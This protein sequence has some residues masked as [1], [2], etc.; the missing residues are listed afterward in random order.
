MVGHIFTSSYMGQI[1]CT[2]LSLA[3][4]EHWCVVCPPG[5]IWMKMSFCA[6]TLTHIILMVVTR[7][8]YTN[9]FLVLVFHSNWV[10]TT[11][12]TVC[13]RLTAK[14]QYCLSIP[15]KQQNKSSF[16]SL[17][18]HHR[19]LCLM[20]GNNFVDIHVISLGFCPLYTGQNQTPNWS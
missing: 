10:F 4:G 2:C 7:T 12:V 18:Y 1:G 8:I 14:H 20:Q 3:I 9:L 5:G 13:T 19:K 17:C 11:Q 15:N 16:I 6:L